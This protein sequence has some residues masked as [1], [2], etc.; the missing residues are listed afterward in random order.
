M[1]TL[2]ADLTNLDHNQII[3]P[4]KIQLMKNI[5]I[6]IPAYNEAARIGQTLLNFNTYLTEQNLCFELL[7]VDDGSTDTTVELVKNLQK[8][9]PTL[10]LVQLE[11]NKGKGQAVR[12]GMLAAKGDIHI[13]SDADGSTPIEEIHKLIAPILAGNAE[14]SIGSRYI[15][16]AKI[17]KAQPF[18][19]RVWSRLANQFVQRMI[20]P[21]ILD[22]NCGFKAF[23]AKA[24]KLIFSQ[25]T[26]NEWSF[27]LEALGIARKLNYTIAEVP[28]SWSNDE[29]SKGKIS[30]LPCEINNVIQIRKK[31]KHLQLAHL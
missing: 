16:G 7:V 3:E 10:R 14:I 6:V 13:F 9:M 25:C 5:T 22:P 31:L 20:L 8:T 29:R 18:Y 23:S 28:V 11:S 19:R 12:A 1:H 4:F 24:S 27:D 17:I 15:A 26:V 21:G 2:E 30:Q